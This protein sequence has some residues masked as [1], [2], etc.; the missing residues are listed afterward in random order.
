MKIGL[1]SDSHG[2]ADRLGLAV[3]ELV[4][5]GAEAI[6]HCGDLGSTQCLRALAEGGVPSWA[7]A[8]NMDRRVPHLAEVAAHSRVTFG[9]RYVELDLGDGRH[10]VA[11]HGHEAALLD[12]LITGG[13][14]PYIC[15]GHTHC[16]RDE[17][18][19]AVH[20]IN[21]GAI[22]RAAVHSAA[23]LDTEADTVAFL[24]VS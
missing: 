11:L 16:R 23:L 8:G 24:D 21:P 18:I 2:K 20:V 13:Q 4:E 5:R 10:L 22:Q 15:H 14:F 9:R 12:E 19:G 17:H 1:V 6:I 3:R 7:T